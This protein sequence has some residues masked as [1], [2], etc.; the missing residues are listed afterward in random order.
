[1]THWVRQASCL[2]GPLSFILD[3]IE[4]LSGERKRQRE[5]EGVRKKGNVDWMKV[6]VYWIKNE[7]VAGPA[8]NKSSLTSLT[9]LIRLSMRSSILS[10]RG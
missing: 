3:S 5:R 10:L 7:V 6:G 2:F 9:I 4:E 8:A 1:M